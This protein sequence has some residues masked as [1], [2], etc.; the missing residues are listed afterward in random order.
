MISTSKCSA[1][2]PFAGQNTQQILISYQLWRI[3]QL[4]VCSSSNFIDYSWLQVNKNG[5]RH[6]LSRASFREK[7]IERII[8]NANRIVRGHQSVRMDSVFKA[9]K[10]PSGIAHLHTGLADVNWNYF[11]LKRNTMECYATHM[12]L[13]RTVIYCGI[14]Q[15]PSP[16]HPSFLCLS[17]LFCTWFG[18][19]CPFG[20]TF[21]C[22][23][24]SRGLAITGL[25]LYNL[26]FKLF[27]THEMPKLV[28]F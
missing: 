21:D 22:M 2:H 4:S 17:F 16:F 24:C 11:P 14:L 12:R 8:S 10:L 27:R 18:F 9:E 3:K 5:T 19:A 1:E 28:F 6:V 25:Y 26:F 13:W 7:S 23:R 20:K 15:L